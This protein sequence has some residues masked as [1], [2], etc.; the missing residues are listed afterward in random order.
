MITEKKIEINY[1]EYSSLEELPAEDRQLAEE[2]I[3]A[4][5]GSYA[6]YSHFHVGAAVRLT[7]G[8]IVRGANQEN[9]AF[10][11]GICAERTALFAAGAQYPQEN[12]VSL[13]VVGGLN[14]NLPALPAAPCGACR[15]VM[16]QYQV[17]AGQPMSILLIGSKAIW[18]FNS[19]ESILP[20]VFDNI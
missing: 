18:K 3:E 15:Q 16:I 7:N 10:P 9:A 14:G 13:A 1:C 11:S 4:M 6:P 19:V 5:N 2:A 12:V 20:F 8:L 17:K